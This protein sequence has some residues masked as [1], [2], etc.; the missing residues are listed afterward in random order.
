MARSTENPWLRRFSFLTAFCTLILICFGGLVT[1]KGAGL[2]VPDWPNTY[3]YNMFFFPISKWVGGIFYEHTHRLV[4]S[5]VGL[6]TTILA[7]W[8]WLAESRALLRW[9]GVAAWIAVVVQGVLGGLRVTQLKD[10]IG[11]FHASLAQLFFVL[12]TTIGV[13]QTGWWRR[14]VPAADDAGRFLR[15]WLG[16][17]TGLVLVQL[18]LGATMRHQHAGLAVPDFPLAYGRIWPATDA[19]SIDRYNQ[20]RMEVQASRPITA[21][22]VWVHMLHRVGAVTILATVLALA[23]RA[24]R[25]LGAGHSMAKGAAVWGALLLIQAGLGAFSIWTGK[26]ADIATAHVAVGSVCLVWG[27]QVWFTSLRIWPRRQIAGLGGS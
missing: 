5:G 18:M 13:L 8:L 26:S 4:A 9:L 2:A 12:V 24:R 11:I 3:G 17:A 25:R 27:A 14:L 21:A 6:L 19:T 22:H 7:V 10:E 16:V 1:S 15:L 20:T 23:W